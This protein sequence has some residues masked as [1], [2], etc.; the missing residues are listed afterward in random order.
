MH[1]CHLLKKQTIILIK[2]RKIKHCCKK[3]FRL[4]FGTKNKTNLMTFHACIYEWRQKASYFIKTMLS[5]NHRNVV[6]LAMLKFSVV[7]YPE[8]DLARTRWQ[9]KRFLREIG[10]FSTC[11]TLHAKLFG[12]DAIS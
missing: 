8:S 3:H 2:T 10:G 4:Y 7:P 5:Q 6:A 12:S 11:E 9:G 1:N